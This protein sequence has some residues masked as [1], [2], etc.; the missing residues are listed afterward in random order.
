MTG[1]LTD[2]ELL[3]IRDRHWP[4][5]GERFYTLSYGRAVEAAILAK[6]MPPTTALQRYQEMANDPESGLHDAPPL[7][8]LRFY[9]SLAMTGQD[10]VDV[11][12]FF[13][14]LPRSTE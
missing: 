11:E 7:E 10:W 1:L 9:C 13:D 2:D 14:A 5:W 8:Q 6:L 4:N 12:Q 3:A